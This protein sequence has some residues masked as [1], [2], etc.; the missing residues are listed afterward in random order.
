L[1]LVDLSEFFRAHYCDIP[2]LTM[3]DLKKNEFKHENRQASYA[4]EL[5][6]VK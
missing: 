3:L 1:I 5:R 6:T 4:V 2:T